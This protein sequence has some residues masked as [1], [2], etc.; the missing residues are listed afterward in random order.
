MKNKKL[1]VKY[2][3]VLFDYL[4]E[5]LDGLSKNSIKSLMRDK[6]VFVN[7]KNDISYDYNLKKDDL[8]EIKETTI[9]YNNIKIDIIYEDKDIIVINKPSKLLSIA[10]NNEKEI[11]AS[12][13]YELFE[14]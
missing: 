14:K 13:S 6:K 11:T 4:K 7:G 2:D 1:I 9:I 10:S 8:I 5:N 12:H 3:S